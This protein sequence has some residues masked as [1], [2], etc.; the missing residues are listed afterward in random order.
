MVGSISVCFSQKSNDFSVTQSTNS[1]VGIDHT[2]TGFTKKLPSGR[3]IHFFR[4]DPGDQGNHVGNNGAIAKR[5]SD[6]DGATWSMPEIIYKDMYDDRIASGGILDNGEIIIFFGRYQCT[7]TWTGSYVDMDYISS[8]DNGETWS[9]IQFI[10]NDGKSILMYDIFKIPGENGYFAASYG[11]YYAD[12]RYSPD[13]HNWDSVYYKWD[14]RTTKELFPTEPFFTPLGNGKI[15]GLFRI[16]K[17]GVYQTISGDNGKTWS[18]LE[19]TNLAN[20]AFCSMP[21][22][23]YDEKLNKLYTIVCDRRG[24]DYDVI[25][26]NSGTWVYCNDPNVIFNDA[27]SYSNCHFVLRG[28]PNI[29]RFLGY[30]YATKTN[31]STYLVIYS[32]CYKKS[33]G[34]EDADFYQFTINISKDVYIVKA[35]QSISSNT[36][37]SIPFD[38]KDYDLQAIASSNLP[39]TYTSSN[40][41]I[42][43]IVNGKIEPVGIGNC[44]ITASQ[45][46][47]D[48]FKPAQSVSINVAIVKANQKITVN[49]PSIV[50]YGDP[51]ITNF[52]NTSTNLPYIL[53]SSDTSI[54][55]IE[56]GKIKI[57]GCGTC[58]I[59]IEQ[60]GNEF[61][62][63]TTYSKSFIVEKLNQTIDFDLPPIVNANESITITSHASSNLPVEIS[64]SDTSIAQYSDGKL[65]IKGS[66][67]CIITA[68]QNG[69]NIYTAANPIYKTLK[70]EKLNQTIDFDLPATVNVNDSALILTPQAS[71]NLPVV[72]TTS[73]S[74]V[75]IFKNGKLQIKGSGLCSISVSQQGNS[76]FNAAQSITKSLKVEKL[77]QSIEFSV[78]QIAYIGD[79]NIEIKTHSNSNLHVDVIISDTSI[80]KY[81]NTTLKTV[82][83]G[84]CSITVQQ[85]GN[86]IYNPAQSI[87]KTI[88]ILKR[89]QSIDSKISAVATFGDANVKLELNASSGLPIEYTSSDSSIISIQNGEL[90]FKKVG[91]CYIT[92][93]QDGNY[94]YRAAPTINTIVEIKKAGQIITCNTLSKAQ[95]LDTNIQLIARASSG[96]PV[97]FESSDTSVV[98]IIDNKI[99]IVSAGSC[100]IT[101][102]QEGNNSYNAADS[103]SQTFEVVK[104]NQTISFYLPKDFTY[105]DSDYELSGISSS[106]LDVSYKTSDSSIATINGQKLHIIKPGI[107][108]IF[109]EQVGN[110]DFKSAEMVSVSISI[111][112]A[113]QT[114]TFEQLP[115]MAYQDT[116]IKPIVHSNSNLA[117]VFESSDSSVAKII[118]GNI[119]VVG[120]G[121]CLIKSIQ[122]WDSLYN[123]ASVSQMLMIE[124]SY[125]TI[126]F[127]SLG[128]VYLKDSIID[129]TVSSNSGLSVVLISSDTSVAKIID[130]KIV[131]IGSGISYIKATQTGDKNYYKANQVIQKITVLEDS[132]KNEIATIKASSISVYP[133]PASNSLTINETKN[134]IIKIF[135]IKGTLWY[136]SFETE[137]QCVIDI[138]KLIPGIYYVKILYANGYNST[139][140]NKQ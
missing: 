59:T 90:Q 79:T 82:G 45:K 137:D 19:P 135:D 42:A 103:I 73:D 123:S 78:P 91:I 55:K 63:P 132:I 10:E 39:V 16:E 96:L 120:A 32:D 98:K 72:I 27:K 81:E 6:D 29:F 50:K 56:S 83:P 122:N 12:I 139:L 51:D 1:L 75:A 76:I 20:G 62:N 138:S 70:I 95:Y 101:A 140:F 61:Y 127:K 14:Y 24:A 36:N 17:V 99:H 111:S 88:I 47:S 94:M 115:V 26:F 125:Q 121:S 44:I 31:D 46:G 40:D 30:P 112:K 102:I 34:L 97:S 118:K 136:Q 105:G 68:Q 71:S 69:N 124:K 67:I 52:A 60:N 57:V 85:K 117:I 104:A 23:V 84:V 25:N 119:V 28:N 2:F 65:L 54:A 86:S 49:P 38:M 43:Q 13:G 113:N 107:C 116:I 11:S 33:N 21:F 109:A 48:Y 130:G 108:S 58:F 87:S 4:L 100:R 35:D 64:S 133:N 53:E 92:A 106:G 93:K 128:T 18:Q 3:L 114:L 15:I 89:D 22:N 8:T 110:K 80:L 77:N 5:F 9:G 74:S 41:L 126:L 134:A 129:P 66:G 7:S 37:Q 131:L